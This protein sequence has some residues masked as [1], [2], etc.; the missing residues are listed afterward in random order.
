MKKWVVPVKKRWLPGAFGTAAMLICSLSVHAQV[1]T[2]QQVLDSIAARNPGLQQ[3]APQTQSRDALGEAAMAWE[4]P[5]VGAGVSEFPYGG[6]G[7]MNSQQLG[8]RKMLMLR[9]QQMLPNFTQQKKEKEYYRSFARQNQD[10]R[11]TLQNMLFARAKMAYYDAFVAAKKLAVIGEQSRQLGLLIRIAEG[12]LAYNKASPPNI[13]KARAKLSDLES[14]R[15][16]MSSVMDQSAA[17]LNSLMGN[18]ADASLRIDTS[19]NFEGGQVDI[20]HID[21]AYVQ[22]HRTDITHVTDE[23]HSMELQ[24]EVSTAMA[25]PRF[26]ITW[27]N[28]RMNSGMYMYDVMA[29]V[30]IPIAPWSSKG[31]KS[32][33]RSIDYE[34]EVMQKK[35]DDQVQQALGNIRKD[36]LNLEAAGKDLQIDQD[37]VIPSYAKTYQANLNAFSENT[38]DI[39]ETLAAWDDLTMKKMEYY[40]KLSNLLDIRVM[41][42]TEIQQ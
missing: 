1:F 8:P 30:T 24:R 3:Y 15:I 42:E 12:R 13:Y 16:K 18:P 36:W 41:L 7:K 4:A 23:I 10:D 26:G 6:M 22:A 2:L 27:D 31:Y 34:V 33:E 9:F 14:L 37:E 32:Q 28:M 17:I 38:G 40:D 5:Q 21:A 39:Y 35:Q 29:M 19:G 25:K 11:A 20:L